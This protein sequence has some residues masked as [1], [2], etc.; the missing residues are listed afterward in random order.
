[1]IANA[2]MISINLLSG[3]PD[4]S[5]VLRDYAQLQVEYG[6]PS[7]LPNLDAVTNAISSLPDGYYYIG[8]TKICQE[9][10]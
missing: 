5:M 10:F 4:M 6:L 9:K 1:M 8:K 2:G 7:D 3:T